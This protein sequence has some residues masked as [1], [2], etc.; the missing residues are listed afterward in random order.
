M[1]FPCVAHLAPPVGHPSAIGP[2]SAVRPGT[3]VRPS[4]IAPPIVP[5]RAVVPQIAHPRA[6]VPPSA[7]VPP[8][9]PVVHP[10][11][12]IAPPKAL[13]PPSSLTVPLLGPGAAVGRATAVK[14]APSTRGDVGAT[15]AGVAENDADGDDRPLQNKVW[16][17]VFLFLQYVRLLRHVLFVV[18]LVLF[19][20]CVL[21]LFLHI[22][23]KHW[24]HQGQHEPFST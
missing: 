17:H 12:P 5:P 13:G 24:F 22:G 16:N 21:L 2:S 10:P 19:S 11:V 9:M 23:E 20:F 7:I 14:A 1:E 15:F 3:L 18:V 4:A 8:P 6:V